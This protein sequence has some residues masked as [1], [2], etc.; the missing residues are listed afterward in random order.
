MLTSSQSHLH[1][2]IQHDV[3]A[4][5]ERQISVISLEDE[6]SLFTQFPADIT[7]PSRIF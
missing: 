6:P 1:P 2:D 4:I 3:T 7:D 5:L